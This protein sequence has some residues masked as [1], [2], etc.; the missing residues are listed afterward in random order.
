MKS[1]LIA[2]AM[3]FAS[4]LVQKTK[5]NDQ[6]KNIIL[7]GSVSRG[8]AS[9]ESDVDIFIDI[10]E[11]NK[12]S[13][14]DIKKCMEDFLRSAK[15]N[16]Y[17]KMLDVKNEIKLTIGILNEWKQLQ[18]SIIANGITLYS[19]FK[20]TVKEGSYKTL[21]V[22][23]NIKPES[24]RVLFKKQ[25]LGYNQNMHFYN[26]LLQKYNGER[27]GKGCIIVPLEHSNIFHDF[28]KKN[29]ITVKIKKFLEY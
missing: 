5:F 17:W 22:W 2:Y 3:D 27:L 7:F 21:F 26:G 20:T 6:I 25:L 13:E 11:E 15:Y 1:K 4:F 23:E 28:F 16:H 10:I 29:K 12:K 8:E 14:E 18:S 24:K 19:K 9:V